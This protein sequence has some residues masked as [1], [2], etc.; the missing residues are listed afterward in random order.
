MKPEKTPTSLLQPL[1]KEMEL[2]IKMK[3]DLF[4]LKRKLPDLRLKK[5]LE[6]NKIKDKASDKAVNLKAEIDQMSLDIKQIPKDIKILDNQILAIKKDIKDVGGAVEAVEELGVKAKEREDSKKVENIEKKKEEIID[7]FFKNPSFEYP[8]TPGTEDEE[9]DKKFYN[10]HKVE[11]KAEFNKK[12]DEEWGGAKKGKN[13]ELT[14]VLVRDFVLS[15]DK[16]E[17]TPEMKALSKRFKDRYTKTL[18]EKSERYKKTLVNSR[19]EGKTTPEENDYID[20]NKELRSDYET[21]LEGVKNGE[22]AELDEIIARENAGLDLNPPERA[23]KTRLLTKY[24]DIYTEKRESIVNFDKA[25]ALA[26]TRDI[27]AGKKITDADDKKLEKKYQKESLATIEAERQEKEDADKTRKEIAQ[28]LL[29]KKFADLTAEQKL[30]VGDDSKSAE[31]FDITTGD[32]NIDKINEY[33]EIEPAPAVVDEDAEKAAAVLLTRRLLAYDTTLTPAELAIEKKHRTESRATIAKEKQDEDELDRKREEIAKILNESG[34]EGGSFTDDQKLFLAEPGEVEK[35]TLK[36]KEIGQKEQ[37]KIQAKNEADAKAKKEADEL[38][39]KKKREE[40]GAM[41]PEQKRAAAME[42]YQKIIDAKIKEIKDRHGADTAGAEAEI[43]ALRDASSGKREGVNGS[44][45]R[46]M[47]SY[48]RNSEG[49]RAIFANK[50]YQ[51]LSK[52]SPDKMNYDQIK[53]LEA[54]KG[55]ISNFHKNLE[56]VGPSGKDFSNLEVARAELAKSSQDYQRSFQSKFFG[57]KV[58]AGIGNMFGFK[59]SG[60]KEGKDTKTFKAAMYKAQT[61]YDAIRQRLMQNVVSEEHAVRKAWK[62]NPDQMA[63]GMENIFRS[64]KREFINREYEKLDDLKHILEGSVKKPAFE[65]FSVW[66][67][68]KYWNSIKNERVRNVVKRLT[69]ALVLGGALLPFSAVAGGAVIGSRMLRAGIGGVLG[70]SAA[71]GVAAGFGGEKNAKGEFVKF[72]NMRD[73]EFEKNTD[74]ELAMFNEQILSGQSP[75]M[76]Q[77]IMNKFKT[78]YEGSIHKMQKREARVRK[79]E[80]WA[81]AI[82]GGFSVYELHK[83]DPGN[84]MVPDDNITDTHGVPKP[85]TGSGYHPGGHHDFRD[86][87]SNGEQGPANTPEVKTPVDGSTKIIPPSE[88]IIPP[89]IEHTLPMTGD[90]LVDAKNALENAYKAQYDAVHGD[91]FYNNKID[92]SSP[93]A[94]YNSLVNSGHEVH[95]QGDGMTPMQVP[96]LD[97]IDRGVATAFIV[98]GKK[99]WLES[100]GATSGAVLERDLV[101]GVDEHSHPITLR[102]YYAYQKLDHYKMV[103]QP[104]QQWLKD[105]ATAAARSNNPSGG[106]NG[107]TGGSNGPTADEIREQMLKEQAIK[108]ASDDKF[109]S[110]VDDSFGRGRKDGIDTRAW[111]NLKDDN[112][113]KFLSKNPSPGDEY[114]GKEDDFWEVLKEEAKRTGLKPYDKETVEAFARRVAETEIRSART[115]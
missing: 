7:I 24:L 8:E 3:G 83:L 34:E 43:Q 73:A 55:N 74:E 112:A 84:I 64:V 76:N 69:N 57:S 70:E 87:G 42:R 19:I 79:G 103:D 10:K 98:D 38:E 15:G 107:A 110:W 104:Y 12:L 40:F 60:I 2:L 17:E 53:A 9:I 86:H 52:M 72:A 93:R 31:F 59:W 44:H 81:R 96:D 27:L 46:K 5:T 20:L 16:K 48:R 92:M 21:A 63:R 80:M 78:N 11:I 115:R 13:L 18:E 111:K 66:Y 61:G 50:E 1:I 114:V 68:N 29:T 6:R 35:I 67:K 32:S 102:D 91:Y 113:E 77:D 25:R 99:Y 94:I 22:L 58:L 106:S 39:A 36:L 75:K 82:V 88:K 97:K 4:N 71:A 54:F 95:V 101:F 47:N 33:L 30:F 51:K 65:R 89:P 62:E 109:K 26:L 56:K 108:S 41:N 100:Y 45:E 105:K 14:D 85:G 49:L 37:K 28:A 23:S 90:P